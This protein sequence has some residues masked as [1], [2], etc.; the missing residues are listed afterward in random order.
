METFEAV[1]T[2]AAI[3]AEHPCED[4]WRKLLAHL[5]KTAADDEPVPLLTV[6][7]SNGLDDALWV[8]DRTGC[9]PRLARHFGAWC[10]EQVLPLFEDEHPDDMRPR[11]AIAAARDDAMSGADRAPAETAA[12]SAGAAATGGASWV[13]W[14]AAGAAGDAP[15]DAAGAARAATWAA[16]WAGAGAARAA[17]GA[18]RDAALAAQSVQLR[19]MLG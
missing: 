12:W 19:K 10:A 14:A 6:L 8:L 15:A 2:L 13:A 3:R 5:G 7:E 1:T 9:N 4:G 17:A 16:T 18:A 11:L